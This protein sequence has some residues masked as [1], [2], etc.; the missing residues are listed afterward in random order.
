MFTLEIYLVCIA[1][2]C[3]FIFVSFW[4]L[5]SNLAVTF[6]LLI[7]HNYWKI[8]KDMCAVNFTFNIFSGANFTRFIVYLF[9]CMFVFGIELRGMHEINNCV[10]FWLVLIYNFKLLKA[11]N[12]KLNQK[13]NYKQDN[14]LYLQLNPQKT[15]N[16]P[17]N[18]YNLFTPFE[19][20]PLLKNRKPSLPPVKTAK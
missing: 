1:C 10:K 15:K 4:K 18:N 14:L 17:V 5:C 16:S 19:N 12:L 20:L 3:L 7:S 11:V 6:I 9:A 8:T 13:R 2:I